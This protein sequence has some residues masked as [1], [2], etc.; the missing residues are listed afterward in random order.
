MA[1][2]GH[3]EV[4]RHHG[5]S[6]DR[7]LGLHGWP[8]SRLV[9]C[10]P[11]DSALWRTDQFPALRLY[12]IIELLIGFSALMVPLQL[13]WGSHLLEYAAGQA[14]VSSAIFY[15]MS[16]AWLAL[17]LIPWCA[18]MGATIPV[19]MFAIRRATPRIATLLQLPLPRQRDWSCC[20]RLRRS[21]AGR[22]V[23][24][25]RHPA[26]RRSM[27]ALIFLLAAGLSFDQRAPKRSPPLATAANSVT[28]IRRDRDHSALLLLFTTGLRPWAWK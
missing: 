2:P 27:N 14:S 10:R 7:A 8:G 25:S 3:G 13:A 20:R 11:G 16:G 15:L 21:R 18:C 1:A 26:H 23:W 9:D 24:L 28:A 19:A 17:T 22:A 5:A 4:R 12:G 6:V